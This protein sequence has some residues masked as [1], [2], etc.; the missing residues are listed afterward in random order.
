V[1]GGAAAA[2]AASSQA[3]AVPRAPSTAAAAGAAA[4]EPP[5][6]PPP[7]PPASAS[8]PAAAAPRRSLTRAKSVRALCGVLS[9]PGGVVATMWHE[10]AATPVS[11]VTDAKC[12]DLLLF[13]AALAKKGPSALTDSSKAVAIVPGGAFSNARIGGPISGGKAAG[14]EK[15]GG[16]FSG[17]KAPK[18]ENTVCLDSPEGD[19]LVQI[20]VASAKLAAELK[21]ACEGLAQSAA[22][23]VGGGGDGSGGGDA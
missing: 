14:K 1:P 10:G 6:P 3:I 19:T 21:A 15:A 18:P 5:P 22:A 7:P 13:A 23:V 2:H 12:V 9:Q 11:A 20:E 16:W 4:A 8:A 17:K